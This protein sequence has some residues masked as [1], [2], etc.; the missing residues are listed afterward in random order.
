MRLNVVPS[1]S[2]ISN[3]FLGCWDLS[4][5]HFRKKTKQNEIMNAEKPG[6]H[7]FY[8]LWVQIW[9]GH[10]T[11]IEQ[12]SGRRGVAYSAQC[13]LALVHPAAIPP[14]L[15]CSPRATG[16]THNS[17]NLSSA[18]RWPVMDSRDYERK[19]PNFPPKFSV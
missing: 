8:F 3:S 9:K 5:L 14:V 1:L 2:T 13:I 12:R 4:R 16:P 19:T 15:C 6:F 11:E 7:S 10:V 17:A 18:T